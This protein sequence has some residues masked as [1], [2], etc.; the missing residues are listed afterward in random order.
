MNWWAVVI[1]GIIAILFALLTFLWPGITLALVVALF[2]AYAFIDGVFALIS[3]WRAAHGHTRWGAFLFEGIVG[4]LAGIGAL[5]A[6][7]VTLAV[8]I[9]IIAGWAIITGVLEIMAGVRLR[10]HIAG[11]ILLI[12]A[13]ILSMLFGVLIFW[14][15]GFGALAIVTWIGIYA[16]MFGILMLIVGFRMRR[17]QPI[18]PLATPGTGVL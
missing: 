18:G 8:L 10:R 1:R 17:L 15:P 6:P 2:G 5:L 12:V 11:E 3:A 13:G 16:L 9:F 4:I 14:A 7:G